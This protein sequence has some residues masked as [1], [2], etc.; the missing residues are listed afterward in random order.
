MAYSDNA[1]RDGAFW[2]GA[3]SDGGGSGA[4]ASRPPCQKEEQCWRGHNHRG[5]CSVPALPQ[6]FNLTAATA[7]PHQDPFPVPAAADGV[8]NSGRP[9]LEQLATAPQQQGSGLA[10]WSQQPQWGE[11]AQQHSAVSAKSRA[12]Y[13][14]WER[15]RVVQQQH[16][17]ARAAA[18]A[19]AAAAAVPPVGG[20][21]TLVAPWARDQHSFDGSNPAHLLAQQREQQQRA[22]MLSQVQRTSVPSVDG[23]ANGAQGLQMAQAST[24]AVDRAPWRA[25]I[26]GRDIERGYHRSTDGAVARLLPVDP[27]PAGAGVSEVV[28]ELPGGAPP[29]Q[30]PQP[31]QLMGAAATMPAADSSDLRHLVATPTA[32]PKPSWLVGNGGVVDRPVL[33]ARAAPLPSAYG[34]AA[35]DQVAA[36]MRVVRQQALQQGQEQQAQQPQPQQQGQQEEEEAQQQG[37]QQQAQQQEEEGQQQQQAPTQ[38]QQAQKQARELL[39]YQQQQRQ[40]PQ[41]PTVQQ[42][43]AQQL[44]Q[45]QRNRLW[46]QRALEQAQQHRELR[47]EPQQLSQLQQHQLVLRRQ[48]HLQAQREQHQHQQ[49]QHQQAQREQHQQLQQQQQQQL[50]QQVAAH[51]DPKAQLQ[52]AGVLPTAGVLQAYCL[53]TV[54]VEIQ[55]RLLAEQQALQP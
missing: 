29:P 50:Q 10:R 54:E 51:G 13:A 42:P 38:E 14:L 12:A 27:A 36:G 43:T 28:Q 25:T 16:R 22:A 45:D 6:R 52:A 49:H 35:D 48:R 40:P 31:P 37:Q 15:Q 8:I 23:A 44:S 2:Q 41:Q 1:F 33:A 20:P 32:R 34:S 11:V 3:F 17:A 24:V 53:M 19:A 30:P 26:M 55:S 9:G 46:Q 18:G 39:Q 47:G 4:V 21:W 7:V 5:P